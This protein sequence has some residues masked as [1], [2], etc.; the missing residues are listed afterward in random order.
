MLWP[1]NKIVS[2]HVV[3]SITQCVLN[4]S[5]GIGLL[6]SEK[7]SLTSRLS[8]FVF[9][10]LK[11]PFETRLENEKNKISFLLPPTPKQTTVTLLIIFRAEGK[12]TFRR[13]IRDS[14]FSFYQIPSF[15]V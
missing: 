3:G 10:C 15:K 2:L 12:F 13:I 8:S 5:G 14:S 11:T 9:N 4:C 7:L 6:S 1:D